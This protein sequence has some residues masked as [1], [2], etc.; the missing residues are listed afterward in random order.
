MREGESADHLFVLDVSNS[1][2]SHLQKSV[3]SRTSMMTTLLG[4]IRSRVLEICATAQLIL[5]I[6]TTPFVLRPK[7]HSKVNLLTNESRLLPLRS[8]TETG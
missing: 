6:P 3:R 2:L 7:L 5:P 1:V 4:R 8:E